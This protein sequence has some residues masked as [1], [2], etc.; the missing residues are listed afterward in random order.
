MY[1][2]DNSGPVS[3]KT[4]KILPKIC[5]FRHFDAK[6]G[7]ILQILKKT[8]SVTSEESEPLLAA[9]KCYYETLKDTKKRC[10]ELIEFKDKIKCSYNGLGSMMIS[11]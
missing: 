10:D 2:V 3:C 4:P 8:T 6:M 5:T 11:T 1:I 7:Q 9:Q